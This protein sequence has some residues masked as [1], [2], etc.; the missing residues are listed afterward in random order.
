MNTLRSLLMASVLS[1]LGVCAFGHDTLHRGL[2]AYYPLNGNANDESGNANHGSPSEVALV[3]DRFGVPGG[4]YALNGSNLFTQLPDSPTPQFRSELTVSAWVWSD[5][6][7]A[8]RGGYVLKEGQHLEN[9]L[10]SLGLSTVGDSVA[11][12]GPTFCTTS[13]AA[14]GTEVA[15]ADGK[16]FFAGSEGRGLSRLRPLV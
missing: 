2:V 9:A 14:A 1:L 8:M 3:P 12:A 5:P 13:C 10:I 15:L 6:S 7:S 4:T 16:R 11:Q